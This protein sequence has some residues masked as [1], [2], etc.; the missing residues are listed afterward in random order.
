MYFKLLCYSHANTVDDP[1]LKDVDKEVFPSGNNLSCFITIKT[2]DY[3]IDSHPE[4]SF[5]N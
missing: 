1:E 2:E 3:S 4:F 5:L